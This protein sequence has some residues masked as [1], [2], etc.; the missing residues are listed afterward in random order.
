M[1]V[2]TKATFFMV[3]GIKNKRKSH[4]RVRQ[5]FKRMYGILRNTIKI[6]NAKSVLTS[7]S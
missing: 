3:L 5:D 2:T 4:D 7:S 1:R 6:S